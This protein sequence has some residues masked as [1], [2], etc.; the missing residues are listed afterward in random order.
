MWWVMVQYAPYQY[1]EGTTPDL[2]CDL[3]QR[4]GY[5]IDPAIGEAFEGQSIC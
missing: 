5:Q 2:G 1:W 4:D 3:I